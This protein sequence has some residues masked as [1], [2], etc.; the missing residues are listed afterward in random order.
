MSQ[1]TKFRPSN[2]DWSRSVESPE[3][4]FIRGGDIRLG[5]KNGEF[6][7]VISRQIHC[8]PPIPVCPKISTVLLQ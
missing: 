7:Y 3:F 8:W 1:N 4:L 5:T 2:S 6:V